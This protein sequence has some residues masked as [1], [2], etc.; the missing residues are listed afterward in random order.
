MNLH[1]QMCIALVASLLGPTTSVM[2]QDDATEAAAAAPDPL[3]V[4]LDPPQIPSFRVRLGGSYLFDADVDDGGEFSRGSAGIR[5]DSRWRVAEQAA[6]DFSFGYVWETYDFSGSGRL[7]GLDPWDDVHNLAFRA[8]LSWKVSDKYWLFGGPIVGMSAEDGADY[9][10]AV[11]AGGQLGVRWRTSEDFNIG[12]GL[13]VISQV[14][15]DPWILP[16]VFF[17]WDFQENWTLRS[18]AF[19]IGSQGGPGLEVA[20]QFAKRWEAA[21][22][23]MYEYNR[24]RLDDSGVAPKGVGQLESFAIYG[25]VAWVFNEQTRVWFTVGTALAGNLRLENHDGRKIFDEDFDPAP[26]IGLRAEFRF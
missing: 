20:W 18:G 4:N 17:N 9:S 24:F 15:D 10:N 25:K 14:D 2:G 8:I 3:A 22:G 5:F 16:L 21:A 12:I 23:L 11:V 7:T 1:H 6:I 26:F 13:T 19:D